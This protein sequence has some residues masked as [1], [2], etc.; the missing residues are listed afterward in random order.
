M[1]LDHELLGGRRLRT[2]FEIRDDLHEFA[3]SWLQGAGVL[4]A[5]QQLR[6][7][8][9]ALV[10]VLY[11]QAPYQVELCCVVG[12]TVIPDHTHPNADTIEVPV[13]GLLSVMKA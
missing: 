7:A 6:Y 10:A 11:R 4:N 3:E 9:G 5:A 8:D 13:A 12:G 2:A 1:R